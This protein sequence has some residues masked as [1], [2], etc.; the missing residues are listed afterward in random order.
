[1]WDLNV[2]GW[3]RER[4]EKGRE[5]NWSQLAGKI[6]K[7]AQFPPF[8]SFASFIMASQRQALSPFSSSSSSTSAW[9]CEC[10]S[11]W[12][13]SQAWNRAEL[14]EPH[15]HQDPMKRDL[16]MRMV[17]KLKKRSVDLVACLQWGR[18][19]T[20]KNVIMESWWC[21]SSWSQLDWL[22]EKREWEKIPGRWLEV[23]WDPKTRPIQFCHDNNPSFKFDLIPILRGR[24][25]PMT[26]WVSLTLSH[27]QSLIIS[28]CS[29][30]VQIKNEKNQVMIWA[31]GQCRCLSP[32]IPPQMMTTCS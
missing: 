11:R 29:S 20:C 14:H 21:W 2:R 28:Y 16:R 3:E 8:F 31:T 10:G 1:M 18:E 6:G 30:Q 13:L 5:I 32:T 19:K 15:R 26:H 23:R 27:L 4:L 24:E 9:K 17:D 7:L 12:C 25:R 22:I